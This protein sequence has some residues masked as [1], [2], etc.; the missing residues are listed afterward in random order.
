M[1]LIP[2]NLQKSK[3][4]IF[5]LNVLVNIFRYVGNSISE[6]LNE[7]CHKKHEYIWFMNRDL[8]GVYDIKPFM[9]VNGWDNCG[10]TRRDF[11]ISVTVCVLS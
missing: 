2:V 1:T 9:K 3:F 6:L 4:L 11:P 5:S 7:P 10:H 8:N